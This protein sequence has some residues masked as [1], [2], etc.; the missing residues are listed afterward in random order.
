MS[1]TLHTV[2]GT[3]RIGSKRANSAGKPRPGETVISV[4]RSNPVLGNRHIL[5]DHRNATER[6]SVIAAYE[7]D[8]IADEQVHGPMTR[9]IEGIAQRVASGQNVILMCWCAPEY[10]CHARHI[11]TR[12]KRLVERIK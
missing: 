7:D 3:I 2:P 1:S 6:W 9:A 12:V 10:D 11:V 5:H 8:L 4:D